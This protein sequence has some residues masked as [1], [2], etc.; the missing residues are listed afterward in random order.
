MKEC[1]VCKEST[2]IFFKVIDNKKYWKCSNCHSKL[3]GE[4]HYISSIDEK[5][6]YL[7]HENNIFDE[8]YKSFLLKLLNPIKKKIS[9]GSKGLDFGC[10]YEPVLSQM[11]LSEGFSMDKYDPYFFPEKKIFLNKYD[12]ILCSE[13]I[14]HFYKPFEEFIKLD[15]LLKKGGW[16]GIMTSFMTTDKSFEN[17]Y[18]RRDPTHVVFYCEQTFNVIAEQRNWIYKIM[19]KNVVFFKKK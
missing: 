8:G 6:H 15:K 2:L 18:Y 17:W 10:G 9:L 4:Q 7:K 13:T 11:C 14:E 12:F 5:K 19:D 3:L 1:S 16:L